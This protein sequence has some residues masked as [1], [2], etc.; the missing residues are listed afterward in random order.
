[1]LFSKRYLL[2]G[3]ALCAIL[4]IASRR[5]LR[6]TPAHGE[7]P[8][9]TEGSFAPGGWYPGEP[10]ADAVGVRAWGSWSGSDENT[11]TFALGPFSAPRILRLALSGYPDHPGNDVHVELAGT[12][13]R[14]AIKQGPVGERWHLVEVELPADWTG[15]P[16][17]IVASDQAKTLGGWLARA[18]PPGRSTACCSALCFLPPRSHCSRGRRCH[19]TGFHSVLARSWRRAATSRSARISPTRCSAT[20]SGRARR[21]DPPRRPRRHPN[22]AGGLDTGISGPAA[23]G[24]CT[25]ADSQ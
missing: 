25:I 9:A 8:V 5:L 7:V 2:F 17:R 10:L 23:Q 18:S 14:R 12:A 6:I 3:V 1:M 13:A 20:T 15:R 16:I 11:G 21:A 19:R 24:S 22:P 4:N